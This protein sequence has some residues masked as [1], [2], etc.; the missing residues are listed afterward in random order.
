VSFKA[1]FKALP[2]NQFTVT[3]VADPANAGTVTKSPDQA[4]TRPARW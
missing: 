4:S 2:P 3:A 1:N